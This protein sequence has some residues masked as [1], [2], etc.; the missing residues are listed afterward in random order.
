[1][2]SVG[3]GEPIP[4]ASK[5][6]NA[7]FHELFPDIPEDELLVEGIAYYDRVVKRQSCN[8][9]AVTT[10][11][12]CAWQKEVL[13]QGRMYLSEK[14]INFYANILGW[15]HSVNIPFNE[16]QAVEKKYVAAIIP[17]ALEITANSGKYFFASFMH[18]ESTYELIY[19]LWLGVPKQ[20][21]QM[22]IIRKNGETSPWT[23]IDSAASTNPPTPPDMDVADGEESRGRARELTPLGGSSQRGDDRRGLSLDSS[24]GLRSVRSSLDISPLTAEGS[25]GVNETAGDE[26]RGRE[27]GVGVGGPRSRSAP[28]RTAPPERYHRGEGMMTVVEDLSPTDS[29]RSAPEVRAQSSALELPTLS[30][31]ASSETLL[32]SP[33]PPKFAPRSPTE[34]RPS[35]GLAE[36]ASPPRKARSTAATNG[37][38]SN[39]KGDTPHDDSE[40][41]TKSEHSSYIVHQKHPV[42]PFIRPDGSPRNS[43]DQPRPHSAH[44]QKPQKRVKKVKKPKR[45]LPPP[46]HRP[47]AT[48]PCAADHATMTPVIDT[49]VGVSPKGVWKLLYAHESVSASK[50]FLRDYLENRRKCREVKCVDWVKAETTLED[51]TGVAGCEGAV[52]FERV[53]GGWHRKVEYVVPLTNPL[54][55][56]QTRTKV[57]EFV[58]HKEDDRSLCIR[59]IAATPDVPS[60]NAFESRLRLCITE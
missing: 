51:P 13:I 14:H 52:G 19:K 24:V 39:H 53:S 38:S 23:E 16:I 59:Q 22:R 43:L 58:L 50:G 18:R 25:V 27:S 46:V 34:G 45:V 41:S 20:T 11:Y 21:I 2:L 7:D 32:R 40:S 30:K 44:K 8:A 47:P 10:D 17:N 12:V 26:D 1:M 42:N 15:T 4:F 5:K 36:L 28:G 49:T 56:K 55:P 37:S 48:C 3:D 33:T 29:I 31:R 6:R 9:L 60:G 35:L 54:G 57:H